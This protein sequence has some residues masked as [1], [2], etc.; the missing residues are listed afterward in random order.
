[1][2]VPIDPNGSFAVVILWQGVSGSLRCF[3][4]SNNG[5]AV[6]AIAVVVLDVTVLLW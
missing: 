2:L 3:R 4:Y 6:I 1:M 5:I